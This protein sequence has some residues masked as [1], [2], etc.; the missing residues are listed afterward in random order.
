MIKRPDQRVAV[1]I[2][3]QNMYHSAKHLYSARVNFPAVVAS[4]V[5]DRRVIR[6]IAYVAKSKTGEEGAFF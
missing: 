3:T 4:A 1:F 2:D 5:G 6:A